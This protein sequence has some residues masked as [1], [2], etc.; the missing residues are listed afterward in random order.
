MGR[1]KREESSEVGGEGTVNREEENHERI[2]STKPQ[3]WACL[4]RVSSS[5]KLQSGPT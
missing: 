4:R 3:E 1:L 5:K 2:M